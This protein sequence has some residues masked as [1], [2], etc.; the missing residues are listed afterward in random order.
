MTQVR[1]LSWED[2]LAFG[3]HYVGEE[4]GFP[5]ACRRGLLGLVLR[6][7]ALTLLP[8]HSPLGRLGAA[9]ASPR[10][11]PRRTSGPSP[12]RARMGGGGRSGLGCSV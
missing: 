12:L 7:T 10:T 8:A 4:R 11:R 6:V 2:P 9:A 3:P 1:F 5:L